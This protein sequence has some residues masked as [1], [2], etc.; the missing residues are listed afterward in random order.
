M[1]LQMYLAETADD[2]LDALDDYAKDMKVLPR[3]WDTSK[4]PIEPPGSA[5]TSD[6]KEAK[7]KAVEAPT[8]DLVF[9]D[10][11]AREESGLVPTNRLF[12][13]LINDIKRKKQ[14]Y[15]SDYLDSLHPQCVSS[16]MFLYFA[17]LAPIVAFGGLLGEATENRIATIESLVSGKICYQ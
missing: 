17:C 13:G 14:F 5:A 1:I 12:G 3:Y 11:R 10:R 4:H 9:L 15:K 2:I 7:K 8:E 16:F 6:P